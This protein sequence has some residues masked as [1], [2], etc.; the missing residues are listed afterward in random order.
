MTSRI[1][2]LA[3]AALFLGCTKGTVESP[4]DD[5]P[6]DQ[7]EPVQPEEP[8]PPAVVDST[9]IDTGTATDS[10]GDGLFDREDNCPDLPNPEQLDLDN[11]RIGDPC[12]DDRD[13]DTIPNAADPFPDELAWP[14]VA[15][16]ETIYAH[17]AVG[18]F[19]FDVR[20]LSV[21]RIGAFGG[22]AAGAFITDLAI[23]RHGVIYVTDTY[24]LLACR[25]DTAECRTVGVLGRF[26]NGLTFVP[27][28]VLDP[29]RDVLVGMGGVEWYRA[30]F[31]NGVAAVTLLGTFDDLGS[32]SAGDAFSLEGVG[33]FAVVSLLPRGLD[34]LVRLD[35]L[36][37]LILEE[38]YTFIDDDG[39]VAR[40]VW[41]LAGWTD[42]FIYAFASSGEILQYDPAL[43]T[44]RVVFQGGSSWWGAGVRTV[45]A[46]P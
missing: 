2:V 19:R 22:D 40:A 17:T 9:P 42:G 24:N 6:A 8:E 11:D 14:G 30:D 12:D 28:G 38:L 26:A 5:P 37:G 36:T 25:P 10:D 31:T 32:F 44:I 21:Q 23:D 39:I 43:G 18:L 7:P 35:P 15:T 3:I 46:S 45:P 1:L 41:G 29:S 27:P 13:G 4:A 16:P 20:S 34:T 33:T